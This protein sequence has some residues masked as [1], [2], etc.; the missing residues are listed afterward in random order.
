MADTWG[1]VSAELRSFRDLVNDPAIQAQ[2]MSDPAAWDALCAAM[3]A[4]DDRPDAA[5][6]LAAVNELRQAVG[7][8]QLED[9]EPEQEAAAVFAGLRAARA[10][11]EERRN[12]L[13]EQ[14]EAVPLTE[15][16]DEPGG[17]YAMEK[18]AAI[19]HGSDSDRPMGLGGADVWTKRLTRLSEQMVARGVH[20]CTDLVDDALHILARARRFGQPGGPDSRDLDI[21][22]RHAFPALID[23][24]REIAAESDQAM[25]DRRDGWQIE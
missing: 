21:M 9:A 13:H 17:G 22:T 6:K 19:T 24:L 23:Q 16:I 15:I 18:L 20:G 14:L 1:E 7:L 3:D 10:E 12:Q 2:L 8:P 25:Q 5:G 4:V 11:L